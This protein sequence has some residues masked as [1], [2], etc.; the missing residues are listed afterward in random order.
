MAMTRAK[1][2][3]IM[4]AAAD[5]PGQKAETAGRGRTGERAGFDEVR[6]GRTYLDWIL[7]AMCV[8]EDQCGSRITAANAAEQE[9]AHAEGLKRILGLREQ[10]KKMIREGE[11]G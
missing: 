1:E 7:L 4:T 6:G 5:T 10:L 9:D 8:S 2:K 3:L 11:I